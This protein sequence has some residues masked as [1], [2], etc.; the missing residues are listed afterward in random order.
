MTAGPYSPLDMKALLCFSSMAKHGS[1]TRAS[2][3]LG[4]SDS[5]VSQ[6]IKTLEKYLGTKLYEARGGKVRLTEA[7]HRTNDLASQL[8]DQISEFK[9][10]VVDQE[11][12]GTIVMSSSAPVIRYQLPEIITEF[13]QNNPKTFMKVLSKGTAE[14]VNM[15][16]RNLVDVGIVPRLPNLPP[17]LEFHPWRSFQACVLVPNDHPLAQNGAPS[18][19]N[20][21]KT[22]ILSK[23]AQVVPTTDENESQRLKDGLETLGLPYN[24]SLEVGDLDNVKHYSKVGRDLAVVNGVCLSQSDRNDF[25]IVEIP[26]EFNAEI[27]YGIILLK[28]K[29]VSKPLRAFLDLLKVS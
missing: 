13:R 12:R 22:E 26:K 14:T 6:R 4:I 11:Y 28:G 24:V 16:R 21:L 9:S 25:Y 18:I 27:T 8:F 2:I 7:G 10:E 5:A 23:Y 29:F 19:D 1:L 15:V 17:E 20:V 3:E